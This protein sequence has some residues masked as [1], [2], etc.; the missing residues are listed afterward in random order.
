MVEKSNAVT[1]VVFFA[2]LAGMSLAAPHSSSA[3]EP[4]REVGS[5]RI[6]TLNVS[7]LMRALCDKDRKKLIE[8]KRLERLRDEEEGRFP[9]ALPFGQRNAEVDPREVAIL[10]NAYR[11]LQREVG[12]YCKSH[13]IGLVLTVFGRADEAAPEDANAV[14]SEIQ[15]NF[16]FNTID[17]TPQILKRVT[18]KAMPAAKPR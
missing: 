9:S 7:V 10:V 5:A 12:V 15:R 1:Q 13:D 18:S 17:I 2:L 11:E 6:A 16:V 3:S 4:T 14:A 8:E